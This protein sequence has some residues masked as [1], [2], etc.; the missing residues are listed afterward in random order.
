MPSAPLRADRLANHALYERDFEA[1]QEDYARN[2]GELMRFRARYDSDEALRRRIDAGDSG[3]LLE[4]IGLENVPAGM[5]IRVAP[6]QAGLH[7]VIMPPNPGGALADEALEPVV[8]G[9][10][11]YGTA[12]SVLCAGTFA[13]TCLPS[14][15]GTLGSAG[16]ASSND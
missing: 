2:R 10:P 13:C 7:Y 3:P 16:T 14:S 1:F 12:S 15:L 11:G 6:A 9:T 4:A 8:G 5:E